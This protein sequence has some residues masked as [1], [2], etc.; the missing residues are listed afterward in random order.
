MTKNIYSSKVVIWIS[1]ILQ[2]VV[3]FMMLSSAAMNILRTEMAVQGATEMGIPSSSVF[4][5]GIVLLISTMLYI[6]PRTTILGAIL[7]TGWLGGAVSTHLIHNDPL[8]NQL[9]PVVFGVVVW[10]SI[11]LRS[12][13]LRDMVPFKKSS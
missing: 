10:L 9:F 5:L 4:Y 2:A 12:S 6:V 8:F 11:W 3:S 7:L 1:Y 13:S